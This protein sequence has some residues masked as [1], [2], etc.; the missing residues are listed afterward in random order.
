MAVMLALVLSIF[1][2]LLL[3]EESVAA[4][5]AAAERRRGEGWPE[6]ERRISWSMVV[7]FLSISPLG[8]FPL[9][10]RYLEFK[11]AGFVALLC[12]LLDA[13]GSFLAAALVACLEEDNYGPEKLE[14][15]TH[16]SGSCRVR[17]QI[18]GDISP[19]GLNGSP[20][21]VPG[22]FV[23]V[24]GSPGPLEIGKLQVVAFST[25]GRSYMGEV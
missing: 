16:R 24:L 12:C 18:E 4:V 8:S 7:W 5:A 3:V 11:R 9:A 22:Q 13:S 6:R 23:G 25:S 15:T 20:I 2:G 1:G 17:A 14:S 10:T 21:N 19:R